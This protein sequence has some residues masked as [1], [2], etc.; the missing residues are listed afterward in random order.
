MNECKEFTFLS[1]DSAQKLMMSQK[2]VPMN[3]TYAFDIRN[4][5]RITEKR[6][7]Q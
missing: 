4:G 5:L 6:L 3:T 2:I 7:A 1:K